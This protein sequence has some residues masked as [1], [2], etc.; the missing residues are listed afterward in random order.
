MNNVLYV[1]ILKIKWL[2]FINWL[3]Y[4]N[5]W[6]NNNPN[7]NNNVLCI[8]YKNIFSVMICIFDADS[9]LLLYMSVPVQT[10][11]NVCVYHY[12]AYKY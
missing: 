11:D 2:N 8:N 5:I 3:F 7:P 1:H 6:R 12:F 10:Y 9:T 4:Q